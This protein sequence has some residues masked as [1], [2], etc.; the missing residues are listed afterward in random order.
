MIDILLK[1][2]AQTYS[3]QKGNWRD[4]RNSVE[5]TYANAWCH[6]AAGILLSRLSLI[7]LEPY[8]EKSVVMREIEYAAKILFEQSFRDGLCLCH[9]MA[10]DYRIMKEYQKQYTR[11][12]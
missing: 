9:G 5:E 1:Y 10:G 12:L 4:L 11:F 6:G 7:K 8:K 3:E 2:E